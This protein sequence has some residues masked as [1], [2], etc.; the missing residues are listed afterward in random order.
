MGLTLS[1]GNGGSVASFSRNR[2]TFIIGHNERGAE[3]YLSSEGDGGYVQLGIAK[4]G[5]EISVVGEDGSKSGGAT[6]F[7]DSHGGRVTVHGKGKEAG[8]ASVGVD[9]YGGVVSVF[10]NG[11]KKLVLL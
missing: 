11:S 5:A 7:L 4:R 2:G 10:G 6:M 3:I 8:Q 1:G 9:E